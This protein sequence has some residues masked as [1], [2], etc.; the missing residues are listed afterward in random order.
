MPEEWFLRGCTDIKRQTKL[1][2][3]YLLV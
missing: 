3:N 2:I 1:K